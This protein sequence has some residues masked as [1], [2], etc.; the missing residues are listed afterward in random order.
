MAFSIFP[1]QAIVKEAAMMLNIFLQLEWTSS[2]VF[3]ML[4]VCRRQINKPC[5]EAVPEFEAAKHIFFIQS[6]LSEPV[7]CNEIQLAVLWKRRHLH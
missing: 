7:H 1:C 4:Q 3:Q 6:V 5:L 2:V